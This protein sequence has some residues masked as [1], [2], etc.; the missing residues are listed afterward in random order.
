[1]RWSRRRP[2]PGAAT[3]TRSPWWSREGP[4]ADRTRLEPPDSD[5]FSSGSATSSPT[6]GGRFRNLGTRSREGIHAAFGPPQGTRS[7]ARSVEMGRE[8]ANSLTIHGTWCRNPG[9]GRRQTGLWLMV[10]AGTHCGGDRHGRSWAMGRR[11]VPALG[12]GRPRL[13]R[14]PL[15]FKISPIGWTREG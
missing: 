9:R 2:G 6:R 14:K 10:P 12:R 1:V 5:A 11:S 15:V 8:F 13:R 4:R 3:S 7:S